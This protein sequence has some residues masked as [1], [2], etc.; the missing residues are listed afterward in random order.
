VAA[1]PTDSTV[2]VTG[3]SGGSG[4]EQDY[5]TIAYDL[6]S[7]AMRWERRHNSPANAWD[8]AF[9]VSV[10]P[11]GSQVFVTGE[12]WGGASRSDIGTI[13][14]DAATGA[15]Q[16]IERFVGPSPF[17]DGGLDSAVAPDGSKVFVTGFTWH[18][19]S[20][21]DFVTLAYEA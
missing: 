1:S 5:A 12:S 3:Y 19:D 20:R 6:T 8:G 18:P 2:F 10:T 15:T 16:W 17:A 9:S 14:Y 11:D 4:T 7:G 13:A 21:W